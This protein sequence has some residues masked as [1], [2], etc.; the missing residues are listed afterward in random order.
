MTRIAIEKGYQCP[1]HNKE[2]LVE[3]EDGTITGA[4]FSVSSDK[5]ESQFNFIPVGVECWVFSLEVVA[6][7]AG[8][9]V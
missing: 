4:K 9:F 3:L 6:W 8:E 5:N 2:I 7:F 1:D